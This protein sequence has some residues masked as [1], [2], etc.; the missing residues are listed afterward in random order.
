MNRCLTLAAGM[1]L[2]LTTIV[3]T[4]K[5]LP[6]IM[7][8]VPAGAAM[9]IVIP[10]LEGMEKDVKSM[11]ALVG[12]PGDAFDLE[13]MIGGAG[14]SGISKKGSLAL[15][16]LEAP[17]PD[18]GDEPLMVALCQTDDYAKL[19]KDL[20]ATKDGELDKASLDGNDVFMKSIGGG[21]VVAGNNKDAVSKF[22]GKGGSADAHKKF[23]GSRGD[24]LSDKAD[25]AVFLN[26]PKLKPMIDEGFAGMEQQLADV[27]AMSGQ[28]GN[29]ESI[30]WM[31]EHIV[32]DMN[33]GVAALS[34]DA[35]GVSFDMAG[36]AKEGTPLAKAFDTAG[37]AHALLGKL[38]GGPYLAAYAMDM[39]NK[40][41]K[42]LF[43]SM[44]KGEADKTPAGGLGTLMGN[45]GSSTM[46]DASGMSMVIG[47]PPGGIM[48]GVLTRSTGYM[49][50]SSPDKVIA[51][52]RDEMPKALEKDQLGKM[53]YKSNVAEIEGRKVDAFDMTLSPDEGMQGMGPQIMQ[54]MFGMTGGPSAYIA[55]VDGGVVTTMS[56]SSEMM[57]AAIKA[58]KGENTLTSDKVLAAVGEKL[59]AGR[60]IEG[61]L[62]VKGILDTLLPMAAMFGGK[63]MKVEIPEK[64]PP[65]AGGLAMGDG[66]MQATFYIPADVIKTGGDIFKAFNAPAPEEGEGGDGKKK[67]GDDAAPKDEKKA[68][69]K[70]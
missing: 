38:P 36:V 8:R 22:D 15:V 61:Y 40:G 53:E 67:E 59:P 41:W 12:M 45:A 27:A 29:G 68:N 18:S 2:S 52:Y 57:T 32:G 30:K 25:I 24:K 55:T 70:F 39:S 19:A 49:A 23:F 66:Q 10:S 69:P 5:A 44:P 60:A 21:Y 62:G 13:E 58:T 46:D 56:K 51:F 63:P 64:L 37:K 42:D 1:A 47:V 65:I 14:L 20:N 11:M 33:A 17:K 3:S 54:G 28:E 16:I 48:S 9:A 34:I 35:Q 50:T 6:P 26:M 43:K 31:K 4:A 7:D